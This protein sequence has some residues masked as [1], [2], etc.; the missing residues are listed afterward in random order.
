MSFYFCYNLFE[1]RKIKK[2]KERFERLII[3]FLV[4]PFIILI[5]NN[6][7]NYTLNLKLKSSF[8]DLI[9]QLLTGTNFL[10]IL[11]F[12]Y[13]LIFITLLMII[14]EFLFTKNAKFIFINLLIFA[15]FFQYSNY[16][17]L[18]FSEY[19]FSKRYSLGR[20][21]EI[22]PYCITGYFL[23]SLNYI[24]Y[25][26]NFSRY[27]YIYLLSLFIIIILKYNILN[28]S[29]GF[30]YQGIKLYIISINIF[31]IFTL[32]PSEKVKNLFFIKIIKIITN[33]TS[34]IYYLHLPISIYLNNYIELIKNQSLPGCIIIYII[35]YFIGYI[36]IK[37][38]GKTKFRH[39]FQ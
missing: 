12:Q 1:M 16:N 9:L 24:K 7:F 15:F 28:I 23:A 29:Q 21:F 17:H 4:W 10:Y 11:W 25:C 6:L 27:K 13:D 20:I 30:G 5:L 8:N 32:L 36:G 2:I 35:C 34:V 33:N 26:K 3:P 39:L 22:T 14:I 37:L 18:I 31:I 19:E 38:F